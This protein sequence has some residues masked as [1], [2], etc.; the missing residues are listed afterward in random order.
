MARPILVGFDPTTRDRAPLE[1]GLTAARITR[2]PLIVAVCEAGDETSAADPGDAIAAL[3]QE[4][5]GDV[6]HVR[7][8]SAARALHETA[9]A[10]D[11]A[12]LVLGSAAGG[13]AGRVL[14]GSTAQRLL[15]GTSCPIAV[16]P[17]GWS[18][19]GELATVGVGYVATEEGREA[20]LAGWALARH[21]GA[22]L[23]VITIVE[24]H[25]GLAQETEP[26]VPPTSGKDVQD[27]EGEHRV[28]AEQ[29]VRKAVAPLAGDVTIEV[30]AFV[31]GAAENLV[32]V[33]QNLDVLMCGSRGYGPLRAVLLG[34]VS[35]HLMTEAR[36]PVIVL[37]RGVR[38]SLELL[39]PDLVT[40]V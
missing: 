39:V 4:L 19:R 22:T 8:S 28:R 34:S 12:L 18:P 31:G 35:R 14:S 16:A 13:P 27:V 9:E 3:E 37:P 17:A 10:E 21:T 2:A 40:A 6:R 15:H 1:L 33:S 24:P 5:E 36:C 29:E 38:A 25:V 23:R 32:Q 26:Y 20:L 11:A 30:D 7:S